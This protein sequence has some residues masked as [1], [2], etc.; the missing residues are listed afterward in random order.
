MKK[1]CLAVCLLFLVFAGP[2]AAMQLEISAG[3]GNLTYDSDLKEALSLESNPKPFDPKL[4][5]LGRAAVSGET[6]YFYYEAGIER[7]PILRNLFFANFGVDLINFSMH[8]GPFVGLLNT[9]EEIFNP[10]LAVGLGLEFP[11]IFYVNANASSSLGGTWGAVGSYTQRTGDVS[12]GF[13][14]PHVICSLNVQTQSFS[15]KKDVNLLVE[16]S[17]IRYFF[18]ADVFAK[19]I[20]FTV[21]VDLGYGSL[22]RS[23]YA[24]M[25]ESNEIVTESTKDEFRFFYVGFRAAY[26]FSQRL[27]VFLSGELPV[28]AWSVP[29]M[30]N[31]KHGTFLFQAQTGVVLTF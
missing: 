12:A 6:S 22:M 27:Q 15:E 18:R 7:S 10:G 26:S 30:K 28:H 17:V 14:V 13:W 8:V 23:Y 9:P 20:P 4:F 25:I 3:A 2:L 21:K 31:T 24:Q 11:G 1:V 5:L 29:E 16:D 19:N